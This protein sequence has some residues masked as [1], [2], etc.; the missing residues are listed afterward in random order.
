MRRACSMIAPALVLGMAL[1]LRVAGRSG[2]AVR[3]GEPGD[4]AGR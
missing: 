1:V 4:R 2:G 3:G